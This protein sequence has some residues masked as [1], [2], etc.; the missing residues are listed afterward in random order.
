MAVV[1]ADPSTRAEVPASV[2]IGVL[3]V[4]EC[5]LFRV[6]L[7]IFL[8]LSRAIVALLERPFTWKKCCRLPGNIAQLCCWMVVS[9]RLIR[10]T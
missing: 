6:G 10:W 7:R 2:K 8:T 1:V 3:V 4:H 9:L 5:P